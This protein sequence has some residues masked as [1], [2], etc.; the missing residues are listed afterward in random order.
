MC[1]RERAKVKKMLERKHTRRRTHACA[2]QKRKKK[3][4]KNNPLSPEHYELTRRTVIDVSSPLCRSTKNTQPSTFLDGSRRG[5]RT[6]TPN[7]NSTWRFV[8]PQLH[9]TGITLQKLEPAMGAYCTSCPRERPRANHRARASQSEPC[10]ITPRHTA[11]STQG[12]QNNS[13][14]Q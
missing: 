3:R 11:P 9:N 14:Q 1:Q 6:P 13:G 7:N 5:P 8:L 4:K 10:A 2:N 12:T